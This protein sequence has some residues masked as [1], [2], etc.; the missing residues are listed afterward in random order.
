MCV[1]CTDDG[2]CAGPTPICGADHA[3]H[4]CTTHADCDT[5]A[6]L[7]DGSC[8]DDTR[9]AYVHPAGDDNLFC[10][11]AAPCTRVSRA[12]ATGR[13]Y[14]KIVGTIDEQ[15][16]VGGQVVTLLGGPDAKLTTFASGP[17]TIVTVRGDGTSL[18]I[19]DLSIS[20]ALGGIGLQILAGGSPSVALVRA[21]LINNQGG[22]ILAEGGGDLTV[23]QSQIS[24]N[25]G[26][27]ITVNDG[28]FAV[29]GNVF[30]GNGTQLSSA[31]ALYIATPRGGRRLEFNS[32]HLNAASAGIGPALHCATGTTIAARNNIMSDNEATSGSDQVGGNCTHAYSI[33]RPGPLPSGPGNTSADPMFVSQTIGD[34]HIRPGSPA[35][36]TADPGSNL[37]GLAARDLDGDVRTSPA[38]IGADE[39]P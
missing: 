34:L 6:C 12:L 17:G 7:P 3:C 11:S 38:D 4:A 23:T 1:Q 10:T 26:G 21:K 35:R 5:R 20:D 22:G 36:G 9:V 25:V 8:G 2:A 29:V 28:T 39:V 19:Y 15:V 27:G 30:Y 37:T 31:G 13:P 16:V 32:F 14:V 18:T 24:R 33:V